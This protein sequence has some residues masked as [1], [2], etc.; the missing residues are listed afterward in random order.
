MIYKAAGIAMIAVVLS[1]YI[2]KQ[3]PDMAVL[4]TIAACGI[5]LLYGANY[6]EA[7][8]S[9][10]HELTEVAQIDEIYLNTLLKCT[11]IGL[12]AEISALLCTD[13]GHASMGKALQI[14]SVCCILWTALPIF[15]CLMDLLNRI[16]GEV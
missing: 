14:T 5:I 7:V 11:G 1:L 13:A 3:M 16:L 12:V 9:F 4:I 8:I 15:T 6:M 10:V 2:G